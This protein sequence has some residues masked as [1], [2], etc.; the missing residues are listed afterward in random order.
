MDPRVADGEEVTEMA[1][2]LPYGPYNQFQARARGA[3][4]L[5]CPFK[6]VR[7]ELIHKGTTPMWRITPR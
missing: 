6:S 5:G 2:W 7:A 1:A 3:R 4:L